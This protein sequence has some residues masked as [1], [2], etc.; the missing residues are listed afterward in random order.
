[1]AMVHRKHGSIDRIMDLNDELERHFFG[2]FYQKV[3]LQ[4][5]DDETW[6]PYTDV[7]E[8]ENELE[9]VMELAGVVKDDISI[10]LEGNKLNISGVRRE[11]YPQ[12]NRVFYQME[13]TYKKFKRVIYLNRDFDEEDIHAEYKNGLLKITLS[14]KPV[15]VEISVSEININQGQENGD[16]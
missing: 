16:R 11:E 2:L 4:Y 5:Q 8:T 6:Y 1:M 12:T 7:Y 3:P 14:K 15:S 9:I 13:I 10:I